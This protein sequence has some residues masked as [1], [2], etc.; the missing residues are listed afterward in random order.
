[1]QNYTKCFAGVYIK[2]Q[3]GRIAVTAFLTAIVAGTMTLL[4]AVVVCD[5][6]RLRAVFV[7]VWLVA[8]FIIRK[9][10]AYKLKLI[11]STCF[12]RD[13]YARRFSE[14]C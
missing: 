3:R 14:L 13:V 4:D 7:V 8:L 2:T 9:Y 11:D 12:P 1:M 6:V 5:A 10:V